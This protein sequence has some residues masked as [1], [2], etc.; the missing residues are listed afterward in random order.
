MITLIWAQAADGVIGQD[1][2]IPWR[3]PED[4]KLFKA[5]TTGHTVVM[6]RATWD[7]LP[8]TFRPLPDR[9]NVVLTRQ[10]D[11]TA[12]GA[13]PAGSLAAAVALAGEAD[14]WVIGGAQ[15]YAEALGLADRLVIT[16]IDTE[17]DGDTF[18][19]QVDAGWPVVARDPVEGWHDSA[20]GL[21][22]QVITHARLKAP[23]R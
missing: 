21:R 5:L 3:L 10:P 16:H 7:S 6:G 4:M 8:P 1:G 22:Y 9:R 18:A 19:P 20:S 11:W 17:I 13:E 23:A 2:G 15:V 12:E 14:I